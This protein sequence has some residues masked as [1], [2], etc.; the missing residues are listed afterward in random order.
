MVPALEPYDVKYYRHDTLWKMPPA[1][2]HLIPY[3][4]QLEPRLSKFS[5]E[6]ECEY[7]YI[8]TLIPLVLS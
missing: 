2:S 3:K 5:Y 8:Y 4:Q 1:F 6:L 7:I